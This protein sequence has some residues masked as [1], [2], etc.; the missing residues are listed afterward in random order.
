MTHLKINKLV[1]K[2]IG[3]FFNRLFWTQILDS[4]TFLDSFLCR[5]L[6]VSS[7]QITITQVMCFINKNEVLDG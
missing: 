1:N 7:Y 3:T 2:L 6:F 4:Q 5:I